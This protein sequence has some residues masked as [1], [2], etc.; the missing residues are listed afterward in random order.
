MRKTGCWWGFREV[1][2]REGA[3][4]MLHLFTSPNTITYYVTGACRSISAPMLPH[5]SSSFDPY[6]TQPE[7]Q[8]RAHGN[9]S[10]RGYAQFYPRRPGNCYRLLFCLL[11]RGSGLPRAQWRGLHSYRRG[12]G[13]TPITQPCRDAFARNWRRCSCR[14]DC[15][16]D[17]FPLHEHDSDDTQVVIHAQ[18]TG[19][20]T[21]DQEFGMAALQGSVEHIIFSRETGHRW[22][23]C[24]CK[25][26]EGQQ[27]GQQRLTIQQAAYVVQTT[28]AIVSTFQYGATAKGSTVH[29][30]VAQQAKEDSRKSNR[31]TYHDTYQEVAIVRYAR[32]GQHAFDVALRER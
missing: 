9:G 12:C 26:E 23:A 15:G 2:S 5:R 32:I 27:T 18:H 14:R 4:C 22:E 30:R 10:H 3:L 11:D 28:A 31:P 17:C 6:V 24:Q 7:R 20:Y 8:A 21:D 29:E 13:S 25:H 19:K 1:K 16:R